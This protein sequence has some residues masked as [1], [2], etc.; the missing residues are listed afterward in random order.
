MTSA[1]LP[2]LVDAAPEPGARAE[3]EATDIAFAMGALG[4]A[5]GLVLGLVAPDPLFAEGRN[6]FALRAARVPD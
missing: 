2:S 3:A 5:Y 1:A 4:A 6:S